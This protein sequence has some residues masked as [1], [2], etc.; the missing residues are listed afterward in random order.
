MHLSNVCATLLSLAVAVSALATPPLKVVERSHGEVSGKHI[1]RFK[2][3]VTMKGWMGRLRKSSN[4][5]RFDIIN[6]VARKYSVVR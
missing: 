6:G 1:V 3:G 2:K 4:A 5:V